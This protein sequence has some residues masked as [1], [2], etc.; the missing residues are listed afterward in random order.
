MIQSLGRKRSIDKDDTCTFYIR[1]FQPSAIQGLLNI[2]AAQL[3]PVQ[4]YKQSYKEF[5]SRYGNGKER[6]RIGKNKIFYSFFAEDKR[7]SKIKVNECKYRKYEQDNN[8]LIQ[9]KEIGHLP[10]LNYFLGNELS[11]KGEYIVVDVKQI[12]VFMEY[13]KSIEGKRLYQK[14][15]ECIKEQFETIGVKLRYIGINTF[16]GALDDVYKELYTCRFYS[17]TLNNKP[18]IDKRRKLED[19]SINPNRDKRYWILE[20]R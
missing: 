19:G 20:Q 9:M 3:E 18:L 12:D 8:I 11:S 1:E 4:L 15:R 14:D 13:L 6:K 2:N 5:Y 7:L 17:Q 16:N 10:I